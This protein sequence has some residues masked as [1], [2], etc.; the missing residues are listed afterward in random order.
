MDSTTFTTITNII[1]SRRTI[2]PNMMNGHK[3]PNGHIAALLELADWAPT[4]GFTEPWR[5][6]VYENPAKFCQQHADIYKQGVSA[7]EFDET[8]YSNLQHQGDKASHVIIATMQR[9][10]LPKIPPFEEVAAVSSAIQNILL[11]ATALN[12]ASFW[13]TGGAILKPAFKEFLQLRDED[14]VMGV[15]YLGYADAMPEGKR[16]IPLENKVKWIK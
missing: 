4:H 15:L 10:D 8:V 11:G 14:Q 3:A 12:M 5:F 13:S 1:Q 7:G 9:G 6:T 16:T 2:K